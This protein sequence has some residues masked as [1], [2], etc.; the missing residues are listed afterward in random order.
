MMEDN[1]RKGMCVYICVC[2]CVYTYICVYIY[3]W[4]GHFV[5]QQKWTQ[6]FKLTFFLLLGLYL[7]HIEVPRLGVKLELQLPVDSTNTA[8]WEPSCICDLQHS[9]QQCQ[10]LNPLSEAKGWTCVLMDTSQVHY[11]WAA[12]GTPTLN[13]KKE[14]EEE[15]PG[16]TEG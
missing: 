6:H 3:I 8:T 9:S 14:K 7:W 12:T 2:V 4:L 15:F 5:V 10:I 1:V 13:F 16:S 11:H